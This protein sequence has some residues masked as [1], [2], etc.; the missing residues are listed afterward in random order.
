MIGAGLRRKSLHYS[1]CAKRQRLLNRARLLISNLFQGV[2]MWVDNLEDFGF[3][4][5]PENFDYTR[6]HPD[7]Y[8]IY[9]N[10]RAWEQ[11]YIHAYYQNIF[12]NISGTLLQVRVDVRCNVIGLIRNYFS[13][14]T[15]NCYIFTTG[16]TAVYRCLLV[17]DRK[18][19]VLPSSDRNY[20]SVWQMV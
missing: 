5:N 12:R 1:C 7:F 20:G 3:L 9:E 6:T 15:V 19:D 11:R 17:P 4:I 10:Q 2:F 8:E 14:R 16:F 13:Y 18:P